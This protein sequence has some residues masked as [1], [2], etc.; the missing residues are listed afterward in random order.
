MEEYYAGFWVR[1]WRC[2]YYFIWNYFFDFLLWTRHVLAA[3]V[4][5]AEKVFAPLVPLISYVPVRHIQT[6]SPFSEKLAILSTAFGGIGVGTKEEFSLEVSEQMLIG[7]HPV[8]R[9]LRAMD[10]KGC[11]NT[12]SWSQMKQSLNLCH[13]PSLLFPNDILPHW[14]S[15]CV[16]ESGKKRKKEKTTPVSH[17]TG[18]RQESRKKIHK[19]ISL[20]HLEGCEIW[21]L[22]NKGEKY[23]SYQQHTLITY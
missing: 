12:W 6:K 22:W 13:S 4:P 8:E 2:V 3:K 11:P 18:L 7:P 15:G 23:H 9:S 5:K 19:T 1:S 14:F 20:L 10:S 17:K 21:L 16:T